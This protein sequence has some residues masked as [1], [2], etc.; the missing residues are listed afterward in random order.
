MLPMYIYI[1]ISIVAHDIATHDIIMM[2]HS[3]SVIDR[4]RHRG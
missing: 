3:A 2:M 1:T 4:P